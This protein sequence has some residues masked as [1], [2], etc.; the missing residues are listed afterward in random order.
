MRKSSMK[1]FKAPYIDEDHEQPGYVARCKI[2]V[3][4][5]SLFYL[6][7]DQARTNKS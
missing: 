3:G 7:R 2:S 5:Q 4:R 6:T 1:A